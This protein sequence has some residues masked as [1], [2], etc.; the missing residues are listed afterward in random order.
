MKEYEF[1][2]IMHCGKCH[3]V[4]PD[5]KIVLLP[6]INAHTEREALRR[7]F[8]IMEL[9]I[10]FDKVIEKLETVE[11]FSDEYNE[12]LAEMRELEMKLSLLLRPPVSESK[13]GGIPE[14]SISTLKNTIRE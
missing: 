13:S 10:N 8:Q 2:T 3:A 9:E 6:L 1:K 5:C 4:A 14:F 11:L 7:E 12:L